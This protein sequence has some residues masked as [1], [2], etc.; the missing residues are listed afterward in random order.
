MIDKIY[1]PKVVEKGN[2]VLR[3]FTNAMGRKVFI[4]MIILD[5]SI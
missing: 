2:L 5:K 1:C 4:E 3:T